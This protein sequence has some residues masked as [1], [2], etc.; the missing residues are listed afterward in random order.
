MVNGL[1]E[2][3][4]IWNGRPA[5]KY[6]TEGSQAGSGGEDS[7]S[8]GPG[9]AADWGL[10]DAAGVCSPEA[11]SDSESSHSQASAPT[12]AAASAWR[13]AACL[14]HCSIHCAYVIWRRG[15][16]HRTQARWV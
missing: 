10:G 8:E 5:W 16:I 14:R 12:A 9:F 7:F 15:V 13:S 1:T 3:S 4:P 6:W 2:I 11:D